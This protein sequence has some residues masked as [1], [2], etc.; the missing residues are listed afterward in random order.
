MDRD[1]QLVHMHLMRFFR[2]LYY[3]DI[4]QSKRPKPKIIEN[5]AKLK[6]KEQSIYKPSDL[7]TE[8]DDLLFLKYKKYGNDL[9]H[10][11]VSSSKH[12]ECPHREGRR[13]VRSI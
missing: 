5:I 4:E 9:Q 2:W 7:W 11:S 10:P 12:F 6:R 8:E 3:P 1:L 13:I